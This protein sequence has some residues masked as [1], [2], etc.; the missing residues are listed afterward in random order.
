MALYKNGDIF[1]ATSQSHNASLQSMFVYDGI[2]HALK[3]TFIATGQTA[4]RGMGFDGAWVDPSGYFWVPHW[5]GGTIERWDP[6]GNVIQTLTG[7]AGPESFVFDRQG[8]AFV[9][10]ALTPALTKYS[11]TGV[12]LSRSAP[13]KEDRGVDHLDLH[14]DGRTLYYTSEGAHIKRWDIKS[15]IQL[16]DLCT[17][18]GCY[19][20]YAFRRLPDGTFLVAVGDGDPIG[21]MY[22]YALRITATGTLVRSYVHA[23]YEGHFGLDLDAD[24]VTF[25]V[26][27]NAVSSPYY[28]H[29]LQYNIATGALVATVSTDV[30]IDSS[31]GVIVQVVK[32]KMPMLRVS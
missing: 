10:D 15:S 6:D 25:W 19:T 27:A 12:L 24:G 13:A 20:S 18:P 5:S 23:S 14:P 7:H 30:G 17:I 31:D 4:P 1:V 8:S 11:S 21:G 22:A 3:G 16:T 2:T 26:G 29:A 9:S 32:T 28:G